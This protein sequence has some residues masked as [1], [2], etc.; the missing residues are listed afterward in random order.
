M[1]FNYNK[2]SMAIIKNVEGLLPLLIAFT[3][4]AGAQ[5]SLPWKGIKCAVVSYKLINDKK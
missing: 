1:L 3:V 4:T 5:T 2:N